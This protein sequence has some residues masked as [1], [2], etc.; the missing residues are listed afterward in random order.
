MLR[1]EH[2][3]V[4][5]MHALQSRFAYSPVTHNMLVKP[6]LAIKARFLSIKEIW[7]IDALAELH[8]YCAKIRSIRDTAGPDLK[9]EGRPL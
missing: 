6:K 2:A 3:Y 5:Y 9:R 8:T 7:M 1:Y 4:S